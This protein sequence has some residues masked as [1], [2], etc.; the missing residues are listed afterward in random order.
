[1]FDPH[2][3]E[4][5][6]F[7]LI[8][9]AC[10]ATSQRLGTIRVRI[11][12]SPQFFEARVIDDGPGIPPQIHNTAFEPFVSAG[13]PGGTGLGLAIVN[14]IVRDHDGTAVIERTSDFGT[15][16]LIKLPRW[17]KTAHGNETPLSSS[18]AELHG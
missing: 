8:L 6:F 15:V 14:K 1:L 9:N 11:E 18:R 2:K 7:N 17:P 10:E 13:K 5:V 16:I 3:M 12:S 4:R